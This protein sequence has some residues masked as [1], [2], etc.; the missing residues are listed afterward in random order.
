MKRKEKILTP[1]EIRAKLIQLGQP[2]W[3]HSEPLAGLLPT[4]EGLKILPLSPMAETGTLL[5]LLVDAA[6]F[7]FDLGL[8]I[9]ARLQERYRG[10]PWKPV[11]AVEQKYLFLKDAHFFDRFRGSKAFASTPILM[12]PLGE[13]FEHLHAKSAPG[14]A[15]IHRGNPVLEL[16]LLPDPGIALSETERRLQDVF[17]AEDPGLPLL[18]PVFPP[19]QFPIGR[20]VLDIA[21]LNLGGNW[22]QGAGSVMTEDSTANFGFAFEGSKLRLIAMSHPNSREPTRF[23]MTLNDEP[24]PS[25]HYGT[26]VR[27]GEKG[28]SVS[29]ITKHGG[30]LE[31][32]DAETELRGVVKIR[33]L[34]A[35]ENPCIVY[36]ARSA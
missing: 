11:L 33:I 18:P 27:M 17:R 19:L 2:N 4:S 36:G 25:A 30:I 15:L 26:A 35:V 20:R 24:L 5:V 7:Q 16:P 3:I 12:D 23:V 9:I 28:S 8:E 32:I 34:N 31:L 22:I 21:D 6:G 29:E 10:L 1:E 13:W 14:I